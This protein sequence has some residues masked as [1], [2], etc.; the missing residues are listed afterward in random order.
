[1]SFKASS[2][3]AVGMAALLSSFF[4]GSARLHS[5]HPSRDFLPHH[6]GVVK[7]HRATRC[8]KSAR[9]GAQGMQTSVGGGPLICLGAALAVS[10]ARRQLPRPS[11]CP[12]AKAEG[13]ERKR[14]IEQVLQILT[15]S[16]LVVLFCKHIGH[17]ASHSH[18]PQEGEIKI[19]STS[20]NCCCRPTI[21]HGQRQSRNSETV[22]TLEL[23]SQVEG[24]VM[25]LA[26]L[27][28]AGVQI[29]G[30]RFTCILE[31]KGGSRN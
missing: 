18:H 24:A 12:G 6:H 25:S 16:P 2:R 22:S 15:H 31:S 27:E 30:R 28:N 7:R 4:S 21:P 8:S 20:A 29:P 10:A 11:T 3:C 14:W 26:Y 17:G 23:A 19:G 9:T 1:M 13:V 5:E